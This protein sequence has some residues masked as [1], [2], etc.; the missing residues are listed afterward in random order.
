M[1]LTPE[2][3]EYLRTEEGKAELAS[4]NLIPEPEPAE[5]TEEAV[6]TF[7]ERNTEVKNRISQA[8]VISY[9]GEKLGVKDKPEELLEKPIMLA[10]ETEKFKKVAVSGILSNVKYPDLLMGKLDMNKIN[11]GENKL[12]GL[13]E[14]LKDLKTVYPDLFISGTGDKRTPPPLP[15]EEP[16]TEK[17]KIEAKIE[18]LKKGKMTTIVRTQLLQ[19][20]QEL[21]KLEK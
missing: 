2:Q 5:V 14:Q 8:A 10:S 3:I 21:K 13:D 19:L 1:P 15:R 12:E 9:L 4:N 6:N 20:E 16:T 17:A 18:E 11:F 7:L